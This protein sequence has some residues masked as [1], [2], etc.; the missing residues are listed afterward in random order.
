MCHFEQKQQNFSED[1]E[2]ILKD[3]GNNHDKYIV[4]TVS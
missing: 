2:V 1:K 3:K 4:P